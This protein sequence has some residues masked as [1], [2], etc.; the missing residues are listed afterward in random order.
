MTAATIK[1]RWMRV[2]GAERKVDC[3]VIG[4]RGN[5]TL[6]IT[7]YGQVYLAWQI[8]GD[9]GSAWANGRVFDP[10]GN[11]LPWNSI[12]ITD[13]GSQL[14]GYLEGQLEQQ[15]HLTGSALLNKAIDAVTLQLYKAP[16]TWLTNGTADERLIDAAAPILIELVQG[17]A[18]RLRAKCDDGYLSRYGI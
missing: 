8:I 11:E 7:H 16:K 15:G 1:T 14:I 2:N 9:G 10:D 12:L 13:R 6:E 17:W 4:N 5:W 18:A 3:P